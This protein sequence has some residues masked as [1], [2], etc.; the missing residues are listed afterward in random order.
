MAK[1][2]QVQTAKGMINRD[3]LEVRDLVDE[4]ENHR[5]IRTEWHH[6]GELVRA[7]VT[8]AILSG[9]A[10]AGDQAEMG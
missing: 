6:K 8:V 10:L 2:K 5:A 4:G 9:V 1:A 7:D 3:Q